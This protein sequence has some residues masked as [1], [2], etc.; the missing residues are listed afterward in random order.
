MPAAEGCSVL[1]IDPGPLHVE[2]AIEGSSVQ[3]GAPLTSVQVGDM[4]RLPSEHASADTVLL[5]GPFYH[6]TER[7]GRILALGEA[8]RV[9]RPGNTVLAAAIS[10]F[11]STIDGPARI[12]C[13]LRVRSYR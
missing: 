11:A 13:R 8:R 1:L 2:Q 3:R 10:R 4:R 6:L 12:L 5:L 7:D 9:V